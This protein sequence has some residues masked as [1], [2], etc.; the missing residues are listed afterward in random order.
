M[1]ILVPKGV[2]QL[3]EARSQAENSWR[4]V[5]EAWV[6]QSS[7]RA[8][9]E[10]K[11]Q[12]GILVRSLSE[13]PDEEKRELQAL[14]QRKREFQ[15]VRYLERALIARAKINK[16]GSARKAILASFGIETA[17][18]VNQQKLFAIQ[19]FGPILVSS[20]M[21]WQQGLINKFVFN[22]NEPTNPRD[23]AALKVRI[24]SRKS[25]L[26]AKIRSGLTNLQQ[27][28]SLC[29]DQRRKLSETANRAFVALRQAELNERVATGPLQKGSKFISICCAGLAAIG[30]IEESA[31]GQSS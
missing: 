26:E 28:S 12:V 30:L 27:A 5:Q 3:R 17:A 18:D 25:E 20:I 29:V 11:S 2:R 7:D 10:T 9:T 1:N 19:G 6:Q 24:A 14:E 16:V 15:L 13:L 23:L 21:S 31:A 8:F 4:N 22:P